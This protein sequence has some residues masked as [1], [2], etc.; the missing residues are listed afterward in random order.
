MHFIFFT[1]SGTG[2]SWWTV[3]QFAQIAQNAG[4]TVDIHSIELSSVR[5]PSFL[6][7]KVREAD[8]LGIVYPIYGST[9]PMYMR[10]FIKDFLAICSTHRADLPVKLPPVLVL[11]S[12]M[13]FSGDGALVPRKH[14]LKLGFPFQW[15]INVALTSNISIPVFRANPYGQEKLNKNKDQA[16]LKLEKLY[17]KIHL[18]EPWLEHRWNIPY[19]FLAELQRITEPLLYKI[20]HFSVDH[21]RCTRCLQCVRYCPTATISFDTE[22]NKVKVGDDCTFCMRCYNLCPVYAIKAGRRANLPPKYKRLKPI[23]SNFS[24]NDLHKDEK[25]LDSKT[26]KEL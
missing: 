22:Q 4:N 15:A 19:R 7:Q 18:Q 5:E 17:S 2:N 13:L 25:N 1:F 21:D 20:V 14:F 9:W 12:M 16:I 26:K 3:H 24:F 6:L 11:T 10:D 23:S 8:V